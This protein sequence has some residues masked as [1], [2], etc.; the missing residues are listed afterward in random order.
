MRQMWW[1]LAVVIVAGW[2]GTAFGQNFAVIG[3]E[4]FFKLDW[5]AG[6]RQGRPN[7]YGSLLNDWGFPATRIMLKVESLDAAGRIVN[8]TAGYV[9]G[10]VTPGTRVYFEVPVPAAV[11]SYRVSVWSFDWIQTPGGD[12]R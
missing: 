5:G 8:T 2:M 7:V 12:R 10:Q 3:A 11:P 6:E 1:L 9:A 4:Q